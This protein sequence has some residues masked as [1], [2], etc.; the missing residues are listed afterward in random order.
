MN[1]QINDHM[2][3]RFHR[4]KTKADLFCSFH[5]TTKYLELDCEFCSTNS[6]KKEERCVEYS[7]QRSYES[8][9]LL[10]KN[11]SRSLLLVSCNREIR[12]DCKFFSTNW[13]KKE[14]REKNVTRVECMNI[15]TDLLR[16]IHQKKKREILLISVD[17]LFFFLF[18][19][20]SW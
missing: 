16:R 4:R 19:R 12:F 3:R 7:N 1:I 15:L 8:T 13:S 11:E 6:S 2:N 5:I 17:R 18:T 10:T 20:V 9:I 14:E